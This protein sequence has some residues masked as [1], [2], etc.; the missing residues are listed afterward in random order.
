VVDEACA[1]VVR[2]GDTPVI[3][4]GLAYRVLELPH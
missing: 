2:Q 1:F 3:A 4:P